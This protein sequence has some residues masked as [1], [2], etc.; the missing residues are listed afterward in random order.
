MYGLLASRARNEFL[1][2]AD[3]EAHN[4]PCMSGVWDTT[5]IKR[6]NYFQN[7]PYNEKLRLK[8]YAD[9]VCKSCPPP[10][11]RACP[12]PSLYIGRSVTRHK[13]ARGT[14]LGRGGEDIPLARSHEITDRDR[15]G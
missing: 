12:F 3:N 9:D 1:I 13:A 15:C 4:N 8:I 7:F 5:Q 11:G 6:T 10:P 2:E 14:N